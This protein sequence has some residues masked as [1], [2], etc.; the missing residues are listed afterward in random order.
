MDTNF[1]TVLAQD[2]SDN[3]KAQARENIG[4]EKKQNRVTALATIPSVS[5]GTIIPNDVVTLDN[6]TVS[7]AY[8]SNLP[9]DTLDNWPASS[10]VGV[11]W[12]YYGTLGSQSTESLQIDDSSIFVKNIPGIDAYGHYGVSSRLANCQN[13]SSAQRTKIGEVLI[14][15]VVQ[16]SPNTEVICGTTTI[17]FMANAKWYHLTV[18][19]LR[20]DTTSTNPFTRFG[21]VFERLT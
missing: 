4:A 21:I 20:P 17:D 2:L 19:I 6:I 15:D 10:K 9:S 1:L 14:S 11:I 18:N 5:S 12:L 16:G 7:V 8:P 3:A 13:L